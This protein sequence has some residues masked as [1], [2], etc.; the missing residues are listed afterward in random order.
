LTLKPKQK[1]DDILG[2]NKGFV[3]H[4]KTEK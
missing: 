4:T 2:D 3:Y 1:A